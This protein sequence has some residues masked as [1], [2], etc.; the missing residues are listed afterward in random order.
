[1]G[2]D[3]KTRL[4]S[5]ARNVHDMGQNRFEE[6]CGI[7]RGTISAIP[8]NG[9]ISSKTLAKIATACPDLDLRWL[10]TGVR[11]KVEETPAH[12]V[13]VAEIAPKSQTEPITPKPS[14]DE[15]EW[16][17]RML[18]SQQRTIELLAANKGGV[19]QS[20]QR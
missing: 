14:S 6:Y 4:C 15:V 2:E 12:E 20:I 9:G 19:S 8:D 3:F 11:T 10:L 5:Y 18:E 1:M 16:Y 13:K 7:S 17:R